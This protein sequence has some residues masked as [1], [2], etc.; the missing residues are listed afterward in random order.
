MDK[1][2]G[3][4]NKLILEDF[5][6]RPQKIV[7][8]YNDEDIHLARKEA[9]A[10]GQ[11]SGFQVG[12]EEG[13]EAAIG[14]YDI[15][16]RSFLKTFNNKLDD[17]IIQMNLYNKHYAADLFDTTYA[18]FK[19]IL[20]HYIEKNGKDEIHNF[21]NQ[22]LK[23]I[24]KKQKILIK[25][26]PAFQ[27]SIIQFLENENVDFE[28]INIVAENKYSQLECAIEW[29]DGGALLNIEDLYS[30]IESSFKAI[31][32]IVNEKDVINS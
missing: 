1:Y 30:Q 4:N 12:F 28:H 6:Y 18:I 24:L 25:V 32:E 3:Q 5:G 23:N 2:I 11:N 10:E 13:Q 8:L 17:L 27:E 9:F 7:Q 14:N 15:E 20:P 16:M 22:I 31:Q 19:K 29:M 21:V 26:G